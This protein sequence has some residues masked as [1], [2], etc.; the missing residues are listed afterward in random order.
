MAKRLFRK[1]HL[2]WTRTEHHSRAAADK[3][4]SFL[5]HAAAAR[6]AHKAGLCRTAVYRA[7]LAAKSVGQALSHSEAQTEGTGT[8]FEP[9]AIME[10]ELALTDELN[11]LW[12]EIRDCVQEGGR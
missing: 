10:Q 2:G 12:N 3:Y 1:R 5:A 7:V 8:T 4:D 9:R 11:A 6:R